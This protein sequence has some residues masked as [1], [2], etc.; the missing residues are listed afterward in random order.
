[1]V[2]VGTIDGA[3]PVFKDED[4]MPPL[5]YPVIL[6]CFKA[7]L[8][9]WYVTDYV[10]AKDGALQWAGINL[11]KFSLKS[12]AQLMYEHVQAGGTIEQVRETRPEWDDWPFHY[13]FRLPW[14]GRPLYIE[15]VLVD[16][17][18]KDPYIR[19]VRIQD[20]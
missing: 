14:F 11:D 15:T 12:L 19:I 5:T 3:A 1:V 7:V 17:D 16:D 6:A 9:N 18:P 20:A 2:L 4:Q 10:T 8:C 13:D